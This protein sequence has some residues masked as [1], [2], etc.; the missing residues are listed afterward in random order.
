MGALLL[1]FSVR[2]P[3]LGSA[4]HFLRNLVSTGTLLSAHQ[5]TDRN[6]CRRQNSQIPGLR[7]QRPRPQRLFSGAISDDD[8]L[9]P[10][11]GGWVGSPGSS[12]TPPARTG[13]SAS[14]AAGAEEGASESSSDGSPPP[15]LAAFTD[16]FL[17]GHVPFGDLG[18]SQAM[19]ERLASRGKNGSTAIQAQAIP[20]ILRG[21]REVVVAAETGSG[22]SRMPRAP[23]VSC[24]VRMSTSG[25]FLA[26]CLSVCLPACLPACL[27]RI[28]LARRAFVSM[29]P[30]VLCARLS[31]RAQARPL[32]T[33]F[34][35]SS[36]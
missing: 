10:P 26:A 2:R 20:A 32:P 29:P 23:P 35:S 33:S 6:A 8:L 31:S 17:G 30:V 9:P 18:V 21:E 4:E 14:L 24:R 7:L 22:E 3:V 34:P 1:R 36:C 28:G 13:S 12:T 11:L 27:A 5:T 25:P 16:S 19:V 15:R